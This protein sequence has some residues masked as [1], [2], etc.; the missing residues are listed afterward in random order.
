MNYSINLRVNGFIFQ[1]GNISYQGGLGLFI[2]F[3]DDLIKEAIKNNDKKLL[4]AFSEVINQS[5]LLDAQY[6]METFEH[7]Y[8]QGQGYEYLNYNYRLNGLLELKQKAELIINNAIN[9]SE[10]E[11]KIANNILNTLDGRPPRKILPEKTPAQKAKAAFERKKEKFRL[12]LTIRDGYKCF[13]CGNDKENSLCVVKKDNLNE[14]YDFD[15]LILKCRSC[16]TKESNKERNK[17]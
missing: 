15:N 16:H 4:E 9:C 11:I 8:L 6:T 5:E 1:F 12:K 7:Y 13:K 2:D 14:S 3:S 17:K 10:Y